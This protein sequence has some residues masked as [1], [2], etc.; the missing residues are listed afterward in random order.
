VSELT[1][2]ASDER[3]GDSTHPAVLTLPVPPSLNV[4]LSG[5]LKERIRRKGDLSWQTADAYH[6]A[7]RPVFTGPVKVDARFYF[8]DRRRR[9]RENYAAGGIKTI[10]D[11]LVK[12][13]CIERDDSEYFHMTVHMLVDAENPRL[14]LEI[15]E[16]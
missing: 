10:I 8:S 7:L 2:A 15:R 1:L 5:K 16:A 13:G 4:M 12:I 9:D 6:Q 14:E 11:T 3:T